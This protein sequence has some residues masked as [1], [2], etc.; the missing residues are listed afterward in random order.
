MQLHGLLTTFRRWILTGERS[1]CSAYNVQSY[2]SALAGALLE[3]GADS[4]VI[5][6]HDLALPFAG[7]VAEHLRTHDKHGTSPTSGFLDACR[8]FNKGELDADGLRGVTVKSGFNNV[9]DAFHNVDKAEVPDRFLL[10]E[11]KSAKGIRITDRVRESLDGGH[12]PNLREEVEARWRL[13]ETAWELNVPRQLLTVEFDDQ[14]DFRAKRVTDN[15]AGCPEPSSHRVD[16]DAAH[17]SGTCCGSMQFDLLP[18]ACMKHD[19][20]RCVALPVKRRDRFSHAGQRIDRDRL[21]DDASRVQH[22]VNSRRC[23][24]QSTLATRQRPDGVHEFLAI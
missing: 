4:E 15:H 1:F 13:V 22:P 10:D 19:H 7:R 11:R 12:G 5:S 9:I 20:T 16:R 24:R 6:L 21:A 3:V 14:T 2:K 23:R 8:A 17:I 18:I